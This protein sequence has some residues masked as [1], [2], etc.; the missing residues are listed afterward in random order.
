MINNIR[1]YQMKV[2]N[3][4]VQ[5]L[6]DVCVIY[7]GRFK[8]KKKKNPILEAR[9]PQKHALKQVSNLSNRLL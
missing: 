4:C 2:M 3:L 6:L 8:K 5:I 7:Q 9:Q 1:P